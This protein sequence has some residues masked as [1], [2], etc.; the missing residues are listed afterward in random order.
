MVAWR[1]THLP[2]RTAVNL[3]ARPLRSADESGA[4]LV[5]ILTG[6]DACVIAANAYPVVPPLQARRNVHLI[7][8]PGSLVSSGRPAGD[9]FTVNVQHVALVGGYVERGLGRQ[10]V[11]REIVAKLCKEVQTQFALY[12]PDPIRPEK[13]VLRVHAD[14]F[15]GRI[16][17]QEPLSRHLT[18]NISWYSK[19]LKRNSSVS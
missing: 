6:A 12:R 17:L 7:V 2:T 4:A 11:N 14:P 5:E 3:N 18:D 1:D 19:R 10:A 16:P 9:I 15:Y 13:R 8:R